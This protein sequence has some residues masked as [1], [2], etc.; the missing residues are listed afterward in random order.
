[1]RKCGKAGASLALVALRAAADLRPE[2]ERMVDTASVAW[3]RD[4][5]YCH[6]V[7]DGSLPVEK[8]YENAEA[9][10]FH[11]PPGHA[12]SDQY[13]SHIYVIPKR[14]VT[15]LL[16]LGP[17]HQQVVQGLLEAIQQVAKQLG[18]DERGFFVR[19]NVM[20]PYQHTGH[21]HIHLLSGER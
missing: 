13:E 2:S 15:T 1:M 17:G 5:W 11:S 9:L 12:L 3:E 18:L 10:A 4:D 19:W 14:H 16:D 7:L 8:V 6:G 20:P 21:I